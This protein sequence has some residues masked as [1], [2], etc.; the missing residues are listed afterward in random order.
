MNGFRSQGSSIT[1][2]ESQD[3]DDIDISDR[4]NDGIIRHHVIGD[5]DDEP[6]NDNN[7]RNR[8]SPKQQQLD[9]NPLDDNIN[10]S[11]GVGGLTNNNERPIINRVTRYQ[12][13]YIDHCIY[14]PAMIG[15][16]FFSAA[17][18]SYNK[19][20]FGNTHGAF[21]CPLLLTSIHFFAQWSFS[22][23]VSNIFPIF[24]GT[25]R[26]R[27][28]TWKEWISVSIPCGFVTSGDVGL[29]NL[30]LVTIS[31]TFYTMIKSSTPI[32][33]LLWA[34]LFGIERITWNLCFVVMIIAVGEILTVVGEVDFHP[35]GFFLC[36]F[37]SVL[38]GARW[39]L[40]QLKLRQLDPPL[41]TTIVTMR[42]L[43]PSMFWSMLFVSLYLETP[44]I[45]LQDRPFRQTMFDLFGL[46]M[47][48][49]LLA[50]SMIL[51]EFWLIMR[52]NAI[53]LMIGG[54]VK[55][56]ITIFVG[57]IFFGDELNSVN[58]S[59]CFV[60]FVGV[61]YYKVTNYA[62]KKQ[63]HHQ[64]QHLH[65]R[66]EDDDDDD[67]DSNAGGGGHN[68]DRS[69]SPRVGGR[70]T[71]RVNAANGGDGLLIYT[72]VNAESDHHPRSGS[73]NLDDTIISS[74]N[75]RLSSRRGD[76]STGILEY[77]KNSRILE[78]GE[79]TSELSST[80]SIITPRNISAS[81]II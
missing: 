15:W 76:S 72:K 69:L 35:V 19:F 64:Q 67:K 60:V 56:M 36:L 37:A 75:N 3:N 7:Y 70:V 14:L 20:V 53:V 47:V 73:L 74:N 65:R 1:S 39:T 31:M 32:F 40:V 21:P 77:R 27:N 29:S 62:D 4:D 45:K 5:D 8:S 34:Y 78:T 68:M 59:G 55:E 28:M 44:W 24:C 25:E 46:G 81:E 33:V 6:E 54:V 18:S 50:I 2:M 61:I 52:S 66:L 42:L 71:L 48:G 80:T 23:I 30:S 12:Q 11:M 22:Y 49:A 43:S 26:I 9:M 17:L 41:K 79:S 10:N 58:L 13:F 51:C 63:H 16:F 57:V 38:S